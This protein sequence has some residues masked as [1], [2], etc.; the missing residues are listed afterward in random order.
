VP[1]TN[2]NLQNALFSSKLNGTQ[3]F[4]KNGSMIT[5]KVIEKCMKGTASM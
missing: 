5:W 1:H 2:K 4:E 3:Q